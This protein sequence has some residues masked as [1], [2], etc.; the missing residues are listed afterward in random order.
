MEWASCTC[1]RDLTHKIRFSPC[2][3]LLWHHSMQT[4]VKTV[5][6]H[7]KRCRILL[8]GFS[9]CGPLAFTN[10]WATTNHLESRLH[11][12]QPTVGPTEVWPPPRTEYMYLTRGVR[13]QITDPLYSNSLYSGFR[14]RIPRKS[15]CIRLSLMTQNPKELMTQKQKLLLDSPSSRASPPCQ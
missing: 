1:W 2:F 14:I 3:S 11:M 9:I 15:I 7:F 5:P 12:R 8:S 4:S 10:Y 6:R 13:F